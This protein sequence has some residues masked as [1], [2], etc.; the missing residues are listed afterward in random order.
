MG[1][2]YFVGALPGE[3]DKNRNYLS[4]NRSK[5]LEIWKS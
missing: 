3:M 5:F 4:S 1:R 2:K